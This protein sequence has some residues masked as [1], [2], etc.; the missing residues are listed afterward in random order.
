MTTLNF[1]D[2][3]MQQPRAH[4]RPPRFE[5]IVR[6]AMRLGFVI[7]REVLVGKIPGIVAG[8]NIGSF[9]RFPGTSY[10]LVIRT[11]M[12]VAKCHPDELTLV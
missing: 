11:E 12:G 10:P 1:S 9:G 5:S 4:K 8:Y 3:H 6:A 7:G 2:F